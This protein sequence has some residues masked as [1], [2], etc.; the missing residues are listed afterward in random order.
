MQNHSTILSV[1]PQFHPSVSAATLI[2]LEGSLR[3]PAA[4]SFPERRAL[5]KR[6]SCK[7]CEGKCCIGR[8]RF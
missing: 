3:K 6:L 7:T 5:P 4:G 2:T 1:S 8:C